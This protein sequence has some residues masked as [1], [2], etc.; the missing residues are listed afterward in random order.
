MEFKQKQTWIDTCLGEYVWY[1]KFR[2]GNWYN[3]K[4]TKY[5]E[6]LTFTEGDT[7]WARY[8]SINK[9]SIVIKRENY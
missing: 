6:E 2:K 4:F 3:H 5:A 8:D 1:R 7:F 9:Y